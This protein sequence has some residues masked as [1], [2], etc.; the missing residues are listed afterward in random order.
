MMKHE[1]VMYV[2]GLMLLAL[3]ML[4]LPLSL[5][6]LPAVWFNW[7]YHVPEFILSFRDYIMDHFDLSEKSSYWF[8]FYVFFSVSII[9]LALAVY[10]SYCI[11]VI[12]SSAAAKKSQPLQGMESGMNVF[13]RTPKDRRESMLLVV[14]LIFILFLV[15]MI[16]DMMGMALSLSALNV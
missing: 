3:G 11:D 6:I 15:F 16:A 7:A 1:D 14:K 4:L 8:I 2:V 9:F 13:K 12:F 5:Y 10:L